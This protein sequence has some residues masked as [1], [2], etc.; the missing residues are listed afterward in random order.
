MVQLI[1]N[2]DEKS[3]NRLQNRNY[4]L[5]ERLHVRFTLSS[6][7]TVNDMKAC[8]PSKVAENLIKS[9]TKATVCNIGLAF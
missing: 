8:T 2:D 6:A 1:D 7:F 9:T 4:V 3:T 5:C